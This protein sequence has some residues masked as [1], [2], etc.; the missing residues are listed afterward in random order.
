MLNNFEQFKEYVFEY[1]Q[2]FPHDCCGVAPTKKEIST[3]T[4]IRV[5]F[6]PEFDGDSF[7]REKVR[8]IILEM[9]NKR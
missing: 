7:D 3:A 9:R 6:S 1:Y 4:A 5:L 8:D 2:E